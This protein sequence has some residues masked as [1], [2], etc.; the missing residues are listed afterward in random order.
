MDVIARSYTIDEF[1]YLLLSV[2]YQYDCHYC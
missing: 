1:L 2:L